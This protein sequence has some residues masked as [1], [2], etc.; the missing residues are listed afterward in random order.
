M[1]ENR[2]FESVTRLSN[3]LDRF[4]LPFWSTVG[5]D[6]VLGIFHERVDFDGR[7]LPSLPRRIMVQCRQIT[8]L[9]QFNLRGRLDK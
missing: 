1:I 3:W 5:F 2:A 6:E 4:A 9:A 7:P 8:V